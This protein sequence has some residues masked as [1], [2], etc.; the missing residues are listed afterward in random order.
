M[1]M[2]TFSVL[3]VATM[4]AASG[5]AMSQT[6]YKH[7]DKDGKVYYS[8]KPP[9]KDDPKGKKIDV[10]TKRN[11][12]PPLARKSG[13]TK[14]GDEERVEQR[15]NTQNQLMAE[16]EAAKALVAQAKEA[17][18]AGKTPQEEDWTTV[19]GGQRGQAARRMLNENYHDRVAGLERALAKAEAE[20]AKAETAYRR[21]VS[22]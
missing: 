12:I 4:V 3:L 6:V 16:L 19:G 18:E 15:L 20:L 1:I 8:D 14:S 9:A 13:E 10:D 2:R 11:V 21:G 7:I 17:L 22:N 5:Q